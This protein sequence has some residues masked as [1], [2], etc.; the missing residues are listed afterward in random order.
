MCPYCQG[1]SVSSSLFRQEAIEHQRRSWL[2]GI[3]LAQPLALRMLA[4]AAALMGIGLLVLFVFGEYSSKARVT[5]QLVPDRGLIAV[6]SQSA[7][8][9]VQRRVDE[10]AQVRAGEVIAVLSGERNSSSGAT[11]ADIAEQLLARQR[12]LSSDLQ[13]L[14]QLHTQQLNG[15]TSRLATAR[16]ELAQLDTVS[17]TQQERAQLAEQTLAR[18][19]ELAARGHVS[20]LQLQQ[21]REAQLEQRTR[22]Q[23]LAQN[24]LA[25]RREIASL[26]Q[27]LTELPLRA[28]TQRGAIERE[29]AMLGQETAENAARRDQVIKAPADGVV[30][31]LLVLPG[32][33]VKAGQ[34]IANIVPAGSRLQAHVYAPSRSIGFL[35]VGKEVR[36]RYQA[37]PYQK[38]GH[39]PG[40]IVRISR[41]A[42]TPVELDSLGIGDPQ[43]VMYRVIVALDAETV[44]AYGRDELLKPGMTLEADVMLERRKLYEWVLEPLFAAAGKV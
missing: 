38:F 34:V 30:G 37:F 8:V 14:Q 10:G 33:S 42:L 4:I 25:L 35:Q 39:H 16:A 31:A 7:G 1:T 3:A 19:D 2:G 28:A 5:G 9:V 22:V 26:E 12:S 17:A 6:A 40:H 41:N 29:L 13:Q 36:L 27:E 15:A 18:F 21:Q 23:T 32:Q 44:R 20:A 43:D 24:R 11:Q